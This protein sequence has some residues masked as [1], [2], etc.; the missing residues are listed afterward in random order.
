MG[1]IITDLVTEFGAYYKDA[2]QNEKSLRETLYRGA[3][4]ANEFLTIPTDNTKEDFGN[5]SLSRV[6]QPFQKAF[7]ALGDLTV[8]PVSIDLFKIKVDLTVYPDDIDKSWLGFL[9]KL[10]EQDRAKWPLVR[11]IMEKHLVQRKDEDHELNEIYAGVYAAPTPGTPGSA[12]TAMHGI[13]KKIIDAIADGLITPFVLGAVPT[14]VEDFCTYVEEFVAAIPHKFRSRLKKVYMSEDNALKFK[15]GKRKKYNTYYGQEDLMSVAD[16]PNIKVVGLPSM[17]TSNKLWTTLEENKIRLVKKAALGST[18]RIESQ[19]REV[20]V[21][22]DWWEG[23]GFPYP[24][25]VF[26]NDQDNS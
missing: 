23:V 16:Y 9:A 3:E 2:G 24:S 22:T 7:T 25:F 21:L 20:A 26:T 15:Q 1:V 8:A 4:T 13:K 10:P 17:G 11:Y 14:D 6:L 5:A 19:K 12:G 18:F